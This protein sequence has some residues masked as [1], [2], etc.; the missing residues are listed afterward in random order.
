M[1][2]KRVS[3]MKIDMVKH[4]IVGRVL[5]E[6]NVNSEAF[7]V[8]M[9]QIWRLEGWVC[10]KELWVQCFLIEF[11]NMADKDKILSGHHWFFDRSLLTLLEVDETV[12]IN[13]LVRTLLCS[14]S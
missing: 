13:A 5:F 12:S 11:H 3:K 10:F 2:N 7:Q 8:T 4:C 9:S 6:K 1:S 14:A